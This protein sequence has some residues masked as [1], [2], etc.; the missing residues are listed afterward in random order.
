MTDGDALV[1]FERHGHRATLQET[2][3]PKRAPNGTGHG[4]RSAR[5]THRHTAYQG[6]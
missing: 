4:A 5:P 2:K 1:A 3:R 6:S